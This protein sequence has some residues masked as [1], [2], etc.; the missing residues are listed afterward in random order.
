MHRL[1]CG[2]LFGD[3]ERKRGVDMFGLSGELK[4]SSVE[5]GRWWMYLQC[6]IHGRG[7]WD[8]LRMRRREVQDERRERRVRR[9]RGSDVLGC[10]R[11]ERFVDVRGVFFELECAGLELDQCCLFV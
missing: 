4:L 5:L 10:G 3:G 2:Y 6:R 8:M 1:Q 11:G 7:W 9:L